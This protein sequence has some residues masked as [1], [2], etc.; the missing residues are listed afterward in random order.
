MTINISNDADAIESY[1]ARAELPSVCLIERFAFVEF[2][3]RCQNTAR[4]LRVVAAYLD[5]KTDVS[6][7]S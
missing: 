2:I 4:A 5:R 1:V 7:A 6:L 3:H